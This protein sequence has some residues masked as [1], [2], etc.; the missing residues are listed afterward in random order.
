[1]YDLIIKNGTIVDGTGATRFE[2]DIAVQDGVIARIDSVIE[3]VASR[4]I[5]AKGQIVA[6]GVID[7]HTHYDAAV[8]WDPYCTSSSWHGNTT[9]VVS[10]CGFGFSPCRPSDR[11][12][13]MLM[14]ENTEQVPAA[15]MQ[16][17]LPW[18]WESFPEWM[19]HMRK[20]NKGINLASYMPLNSLMIY[21]MGLEAAKTRAATK[22]ERA[23][24]RDL[25]NEAMDAGAIGFAMSHL[26]VYNSHKDIDFTPMP[27]DSMFPEDAV[28]L[29]EV[30]RE[31]G[32]GVIQCL[33]QLNA[34]V[35]NSFLV[36]EMARVSG[37][38]ILHNVVIGFDS[39][40]E[41][42]V[43]VLK[44][45]DSTV[46]RG[47]NI[48][49]QSLVH[50]SWAEFTALTVDTLWQNVEPFAEFSTHVGS[51]A[52]T[53]AAKDPAF[54]QRARKA[55]DPNVMY[56]SGGPIESHKLVDAKSS[57]FAKYE[58]QLIAE[59]AKAEG[60]APIDILFD[61]I[62]DTEAH[63]DFRTTEAT[64][65][66]PAKVDAILRH[67]RVLAGTSD[68]G[69]HVKFSDGGVYATDVIAWMEREEKRFT[70]EE[71][72]SLLSQRPAEVLGL[73]DRGTLVEGKAA[74]LYIYDYEKLDYNREQMDI[75][76]DLPENDW[77]RVIRA[78]GVEWVVVNGEPI[79]H[80]SEATGAM[81]GR[82]LETVRDD[83]SLA[84]AAE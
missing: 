4:V 46:E 12:R 2:G 9:V 69:A 81:P 72:H 42:H 3:T 65:K 68:G 63:A 49:S 60:T 84:E 37:R 5:D 33:A 20:L 56:A 10:N 21:V 66:D 59:I 6:P 50:R 19:A 35:N 58:G 82:M 39:A 55:Y 8:H 64:T 52:K 62:A 18:T 83:R 1:M 15:A 54:R 16:R 40:P 78:Q 47:L 22:A 74:D 27:T 57:R 48:Y 79:M 77:R 36:E 28:Y 31:R 71:L 13:Y 24:M 7:P 51:E 61:I 38:P 14:M 25:L 41:H 45:L 26:G 23:Q 80:N 73:E 17:A 34:V 53:R 29:A 32:Q 11:E 30:L 44:W 70:L 43:N 67:P 75:V 76:H